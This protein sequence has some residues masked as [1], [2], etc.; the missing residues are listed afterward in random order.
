MHLLIQEL[1]GDDP[2]AG[3]R[4]HLDLG[5]DNIPAEVAR[6]EALGAEHVRDGGGWVVM[7]DPTGQV[8]CVTG[9]PPD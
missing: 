6:L 9:Q 4:A 8:F 2:A 1:G 5:T 7:R 3:T